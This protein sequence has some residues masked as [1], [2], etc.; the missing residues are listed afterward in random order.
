MRP[1]K[2]VPILKERI[3]GGQKLK[4]YNKSFE[5]SNIGESWETDKDTMPVLIKFI[6]ANDILSVQ[7]HP[8]DTLAWAL[9]G[10][11]YGKTEAWIVLDCEED[12]ALVAGLKRGTTSEQMEQAI[13]EGRLEELLNITKVKKGD[14][15]YI[16]AG[17]VH[18]LGKGML[19]YEVQQPSDLTYRLYDWDRTDGMGK[20][21]ELHIQKALKC[22]DYNITELDIRNLYEMDIRPKRPLDIFE[23]EYFTTSYLLLDEEQIY[24]WL[25]NDFSMLTVMSGAAYISFENE[26]NLMQKGD[27]WI[28]PAGSAV[29]LEACE[30]TELIFTERL[31]ND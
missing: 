31:Q 27:T 30:N 18:S 15:I 17:T 3:W 22:I 1:Y 2:T 12:A 9:E 5:G 25:G 23:S 7:V 26:K 16:P 24:Q 6:D 8:N 20:P 28:I 21:R 10:Q 11:Q 14:C 19:V 4:Q 29:F 13:Q